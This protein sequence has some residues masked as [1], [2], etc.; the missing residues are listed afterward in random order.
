MLTLEALAE[1]LQRN[2][3]AAGARVKEFSIGGKDFPFNSRA[4]LMGVI[5]LSPDSWYRESVCLTQERAIRRGRVLA[6]QGAQI[7]DVGAESTLAQ[8]ARL[9]DSGQQ[10]KLLPV[11]AGL[12]AHGILVSVET[13]SATVAAGCLKAGANVLNLT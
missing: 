8:A 10:S 5:N 4:A 11:V 1:I 9:D 3:A 6:A 12:R 13:Y 7:V 2:P